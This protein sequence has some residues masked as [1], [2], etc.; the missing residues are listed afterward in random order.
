MGLIDSKISITK[1]DNIQPFDLCGHYSA[2]PRLINSGY[3]PLLSQTCHHFVRYKDTSFWYFSYL[4]LSEILNARL[5][6]ICILYSIKVKFVLYNV[7]ADAI[8]N[9]LAR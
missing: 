5:S 8:S 9:Y 3:Q 1:Q 4:N 6:Y 2:V 7:K